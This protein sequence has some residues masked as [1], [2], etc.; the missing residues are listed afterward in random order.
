MSLQ[1]KP[2]SQGDLLWTA[3]IVVFILQRNSYTE[4]HSFIHW[5]HSD[6]ELVLVNNTFKGMLIIEV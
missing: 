3:V 1:N 4:I 2:R 5:T 6:S